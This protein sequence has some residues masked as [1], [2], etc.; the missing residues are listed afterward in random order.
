MANVL[1]S[2]MVNPTQPCPGNTPPFH[3]VLF[4]RKNRGLTLIEL[5]VAL[6]IVSIMAAFATVSFRPLWDKHRLNISTQELNGFVQLLRMKAILKK[7]TYQIKF[8]DNDIFYRKKN[9]QNWD[10]WLKREMSD[11]TQYSMTGSSYF[12]SKGFAS[13]KTITLAVNNYH[14][15][16]IININGR[17]RTTTIY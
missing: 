15:K 2:H 4:T 1:N 13:P 11:A 6:C 3:H 16:L 8:V 14:Q 10:N 7:C 5:L 12:Y 17:T 9:K